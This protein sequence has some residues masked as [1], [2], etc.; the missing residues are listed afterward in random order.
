MR[1]LRAAAILCCLSLMA[2]L[3]GCATQSAV[4]RGG[5]AS[6]SGAQAAPGVGGKY[7]IA[8]GAIIDKSAPDSEKSL[9]RQLM[10][11]NA[12]RGE[13]DRMQPSAVIGGIRDMLVTDLFGSDRFIVLERESLDAVLS[14]QEFSQ[15]ASAGDTTRIPLKQLEGAELIVLGAITAFDAGLDGGAIPIPIPLGNRGNFGLMN[16]SFKRGAVMMDLRVIDARTGRVLTSVAVEGKST[17]FGMNFT[18]F[19]G[20]GGSTIKL[21]GLLS[22]FQNTPVEEALQKMVTAAVDEIVKKTR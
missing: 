6:I 4:T 15:S 21:P 2:G 13:Q 1:A 12:T 16:L 22:Y 11:I 10:R 20:V 19:F 17:N 14:E 3:A 9:G 7:R 5:G 18:G 8:V